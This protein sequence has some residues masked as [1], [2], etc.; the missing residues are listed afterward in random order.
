MSSNIETTRICEY[1]NDQFTARTTSTKYCSHKCN[2]RD[3]KAKL[4]Q[5]KI[6]ASNNETLKKS[7]FPLEQL[8]AKEFL[9]VKEVATLL[10][11]S[12]RTVYRFIENGNIK[13]VNLWQRM[14]RIKRSALDK[15]FIA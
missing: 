6:K 12:L 1:C 10:N 14:T 4:K 9:T 13:A 3:Y 5:A 8:K 7:I 11:C 2:S 15:L